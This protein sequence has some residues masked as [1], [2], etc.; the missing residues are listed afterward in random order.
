MHIPVLIAADDTNVLG[1]IKGSFDSAATLFN[2]ESAVSSP[3]KPT[4]IR[5]LVCHLIRLVHPL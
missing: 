2:T 5:S 4:T 3:L 1:S